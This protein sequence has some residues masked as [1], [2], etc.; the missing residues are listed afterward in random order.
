[1][2]EELPRVPGRGSGRGRG[3]GEQL[4]HEGLSA[5]LHESE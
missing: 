4:A 1:M 3:L 5:N 2:V